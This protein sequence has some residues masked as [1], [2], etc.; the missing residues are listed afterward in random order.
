MIVG[1]SFECCWFRHT[2]PLSDARA[3]MI[4]G[5]S[6]QVRRIAIAYLH[7][8]IAL[9]GATT[10]RQ[11][12]L[13]FYEKIL[14]AGLEYPEMVQQGSELVLLNRSGGPETLSEVRVGNIAL[15]QG[16]P[17]PGTQ[18]PAHFRFLFAE[19]NSSKALKFVQDA[20]ETMYDA[21]RH[22]WGPRLGPVVL[23]E[24][25]MTA[26]AQL[27]QGETAAAYLRN[28]VTRVGEQAQNRLGR[29]FEQVHLKLVSGA[30]I[31]IGEGAP[32]PPLPGAYVELTLEPVIPE[33]QLVVLNMLVRWQAVRLDLK[34]LQLPPQLRDVLAGKEFIA[35]NQ[36]AQAPTFYI[37]QVYNYLQ[38]NAVSF[39]DA[40]GR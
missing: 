3:I 19:Q 32:Q 21:G 1:Q 7:P 11:D 35:F 26:T 24:V 22:I 9:Q 28:K 38:S 25:S 27:P 39:L 31:V 5:S 18:V 37:D 16:P 13:H 8:P 10:Q 4:A 36:E 20:A 33:Q 23:V 30:P 2:F 6:L 40:V 15:A 17:A 14:S 34:Q 12:N 29:E